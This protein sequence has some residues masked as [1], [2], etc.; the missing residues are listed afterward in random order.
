MEE[1]LQAAR[2]SGRST[3]AY[4][5]LVNACSAGAEGVVPRLWPSGGTLRVALERTVITR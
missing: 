3:K 1:F 2:G 4:Q 5:M